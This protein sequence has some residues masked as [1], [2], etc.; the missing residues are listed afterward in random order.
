M[1][2]VEKQKRFNNLCFQIKELVMSVFLILARNPGA[3]ATNIDYPVLFIKQA[4][5]EYNLLPTQIKR[6]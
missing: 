4:Q 5:D 1:F 6:L 2:I 3:T